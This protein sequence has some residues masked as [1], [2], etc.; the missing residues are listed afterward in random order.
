MADASL[1][2]K[3]IADEGADMAVV[4]RFG[5]QEASGRGFAAEMLDIMSR[6]IPLL[7]IVQDE[8]LPAWR[9]FTGGVAAELPSN[10]EH[11][12]GWLRYKLRQMQVA[13]NDLEQTP[14]ANIGALISPGAA[15]A[16]GCSLAVGAAREMSVNTVTT[17]LVTRDTKQTLRNGALSDVRHSRNLMQQELA[18]NM[19]ASQAQIAQIERKSDMLLST[20]RRYVNGLGGELDLVARFPGVSYHLGR[21]SD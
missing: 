17:T 16:H 14:R 1:I 2:L 20:L 7:T 19:D 12:M 11:V 3:R 9:E 13:R 6:G 8:Y 4:N 21:N 5:K 15:L 18:E 10:F